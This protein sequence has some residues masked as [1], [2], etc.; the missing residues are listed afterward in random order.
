MKSRRRTGR[1]RPRQSAGVV[2]VQ[3]GTRGRVGRTNGVARAC[4]HRKDHRLVGLQ[5]R[6]AERVS[7]YGCRRAAGEE[8][9][10]AGTGVDEGG[11]MPSVIAAW[12][13]KNSRPADREVHR[14]RTRNNA[15]AR[16]GVDHVGRTILKHRGR[17]Y[18]YRDLSV[19]VGDGAGRHAGRTD[20][21]ARARRHGQNHRLVEF[22]R[23]VSGRVNRHGRRRTAGEEG[24]RPGGRG[25]AGRATLRVVG[26][27][28][29]RPVDREV[30][31]QR[32]GGDAVT[33]E[34]VDEVPRTVLGGRQ[35]GY[36][37]RHVRIVVGDCPRR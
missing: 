29:G 5:I 14:Q 9:H 32:A 27:E 35:R 12:R 17:R 23:A 1:N 8:V 20:V 3:D 30:D 33:R 36:C 25:E 31:R 26:V 34:R 7:R 4:G 16:E 10:R 6:V 2:V 18:G 19:V 11:R 13:S 24:H 15:G 21:V 22:G 28:G 37:Y